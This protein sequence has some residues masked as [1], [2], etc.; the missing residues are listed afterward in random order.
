[1]LPEK[2]R[3]GWARGLFLLLLMCWTLPS[4]AQYF[5]QNKVR[6]R[7]FDFQ[8]LQ[9]EHFDIYYYPEEQEAVNQAAQMAERWYARLSRVLNH[10]LPPQ[11]PIIL[12]DSSPSFRSTTVVPGM[13]GESTGGV[14]EG[15][16]RRVVLPFAG[17][18]AETDHVLG[19][20]LVHAFQYHM[21]SPGAGSGLGGA[22][23]LAALP[24]WFIEGMAEYLSLGSFDPHTAM[25]MRDAIAQDDLPDINELDNPQYFPYRY[26]H[27]FWAYVAGRFGDDVV[28]RMLL[29]ASR[30]GRVDSAISSVLQVSMDE[31]SQQ[32]KEA[33]T[34]QYQ[35]ILDQS[36]NA[37]LAES[38]LISDDNAGEINLSPA[39]S[40]DGNLLVFFSEKGLFSIDLYLADA[41]TGRIIDRITDSALNP[42][43]DSFQ[44]VTSAGAW[45]A[46]GR[47]FVYPS[48]AEGRPVLSFYDVE[49]RDVTRQIRFDDL[50]EILHPTWS[51]D[52]S[53]VAFSAVKGGLL[54]L[55][56][57]NIEA[58]QVQN[59]TEDPFAELQ[60]AWSPDGRR[61][62]FVTDRFGGNAGTL[63]GG[64]Y[65]LAVLDVNSR[66]VARLPG[67]MSG[68]HISPQWTADSRGLYFVSDQNGVSNIYLASLQGG[69]I[70]QVTNV[71]TGV[72]GIAA[73]SPALSFAT[74]GNR[75]VFSLI[76]DSKYSIYSV[77]DATTFSRSAAEFNRLKAGGLPP[78][79]R[80][81]PQTPPGAAPGP[82]G[83]IA[84][85]NPA[86][87]YDSMRYE[88]DLSLEY[89]APLNISLGSTSFGSLVGGGIGL[90]W[91]DLL[92]QH[93]LL[94]GIQTSTIMDGNFLNNLSAVVGYQNQTSRWDWGIMAAQVPY[95]TGN[96][97]RGVTT[98]DGDPALVEQ[99]ETLW[100]IER[101]VS[102]LL[103]YPFNRAQR[104]EFSLGYQNIA[105]DA[106]ARTTVV[107]SLG[108]LLAEDTTDLPTPNALNMGIGSA[109]LVFDTSIFGGTSPIAGTRYRLELGGN[110]GTLSYSTALA[111]FRHYVQ[112]GRSFS[113]AG[114][115][116]HYGRYGGAS[117]D[118]RLQSLFLGYTSMVR[119]YST[120]TFSLRE[121]GVDAAETGSCPVYDQ[122]FG[123][124]ILVGN[125][126]GR[127]QLVGP[128][129]LYQTAR[130]PPI[131]IAPFY[132]AGLAWTSDEQADLFD[133]VR[134]PV[135]STGIS[136]RVNLLGF[137][138]F[139]ASFVHP[140]DRPLKK[141]MW[142][143]GLVTGF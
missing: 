45:S 96:L 31:L 59:L 127:L 9:T 83:E 134:S 86:R 99:S 27:A 39:V 87:Q 29:A 109:A 85:L 139:Q 143:F 100:Q 78:L 12:Y 34:R 124:R 70:R 11:Q 61:I 49:D 89:V 103:A 94:T 116:L 122:L 130:V 105:F 65:Q 80:R 20:E 121:C 58:E 55:Y 22:S 140:I 136:A 21:A 129:G 102:G 73:L 17:P 120:N 53:R 125:V 113:L 117:E 97:F 44:F 107:S 7:S 104:L 119:G 133:L 131:E 37:A 69:P 108:Q 63:S 60:P 40:P 132:D 71:Q 47:Q 32:W 24:L 79:D 92:G 42:H 66:E 64:S 23:A 81:T 36:S 16:R 5:G 14:T 56:V 3:L 126:E 68:K 84:G 128:V 1:M 77:A 28:S 142:E 13:I 52:G 46:D 115:A 98:V 15:L 38:K 54:D 50:G 62:A 123:S 72:T 57:V 137:A 26:G 90:Y 76:E 95:V 10:E 33:L 30:T 4:A 138:V 2:W 141:W 111:D 43:F 67:F 88:P 41:Q 112:I 118:S 18:L 51:P 106:E 114:R 48:I 35:P 25:W 8:V 74:E 82:P 75:L 110:A 135:S 93:N 6:Y 19:H 101:Q 91:S